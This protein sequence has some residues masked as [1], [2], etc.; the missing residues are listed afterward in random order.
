MVLMRKWSFQ[1]SRDFFEFRA[2]PVL[3][4]NFLFQIIQSEEDTDEYI[5]FIFDNI[6]KQFLEYENEKRI[7][8]F[9]QLNNLTSPN[10]S[11]S[12]S[13]SAITNSHVVTNNINNNINGNEFAELD[14]ISIPLDKE[15]DPNRILGMYLYY[16]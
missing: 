14:N 8:L 4:R 12:N 16:K 15:L 2:V 11:P 9:N 6:Q 1:Y 7:R 3:F 5:E 13:S 10:I